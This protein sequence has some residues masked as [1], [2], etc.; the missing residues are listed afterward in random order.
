MERKWL[1][2]ARIRGCPLIR[3]RFSLSVLSSPVRSSANGIPAELHTHFKGLVSGKISPMRATT[4]LESSPNG[5]RSG[6]FVLDFHMIL[7]TSVSS[8]RETIR[9]L[10]PLKSVDRKAGFY[11]YR[12]KSF[13]RP[14]G[15]FDAIETSE[16]EYANKVMTLVY[17]QTRL[18]IVI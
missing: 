18:Y 17:P 5:G 12:R 8:R 1:E 10:I 13:V 9:K 11:E 16:T 4:C 2:G 14:Y 3:Q 15:V 6:N 7:E